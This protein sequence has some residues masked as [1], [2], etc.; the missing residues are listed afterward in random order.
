[1]T[2]EET[3]IPLGRHVK[4][5]TG[6]AYANLSSWP[7]PDEGALN[8]Q[9]LKDYQQRKEGIQLY[10][11][12]ASVAFIRRECGLE[13]KYIY[14]L[15][16]ERCL[17]VHPDGLIYGWRGIVPRLHIKP[18]RR[19]KLIS[20]D[21]AGFG[22]AGAL[23]V[24]LELHPDL[25]TKFDQRILHSPTA[26]Q[27]GPVQRPRQSLWKWFLDELRKLGYETRHEWPFNTRTN[28]Y[29][30][31]RKY[32]DSILE[33]NPGRA[34]RVIGG[35]DLGRKMLSGDGVD[36]PV[37]HVYQRVEMDAHKID[38]IFCVLLP[39]SAGGYVPKIIYRIWVI[40]IIEIVSR[41][42]L[43]YF[44][45]LRREVS[46]EDVLRT[47][48]IALSSWSPRKLSFS[49]I[50]YA[51]GAGFPSN[52]SPKLFRACWNETSVDGA[53]AETC[54]H[55]RDS[56]KNVVGSVLVSPK[57]GFSSR[58]SK[59]DRPFIEAFFKKLGASGF[60]RISN[61]TGGK[62]GGTNGRD[63]SKV[64]IKSQF[65]I[66][67]AEELL[68]VLIANYNATP[69]TALGYRSP[70]Q[71]LDFIC[72]RNDL[73]LRYADPNSVQALLSYR[74]RCRVKGGIRE[75]RRPYVNFEGAR[76]TN[77]ILGQRH[78]LVGSYIWLI[79][80][81]EDDARVAQ[82]STID[83]MSLGIL[84][85]AA[86]W[87]KLPHSLQVRRAINSCVHQRMLFIASGSDAVEAFLG[88]CEQQRNHKLPVHPAYLEARRI[89]VQEAE[90]VVGKP[91]LEVASEQQKTTLQKGHQ[92][93]I[94]TDKARQD[95]EPSTKLLPVRRKAVST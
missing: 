83:G 59:D 60:Q 9:K 55:V 16:R 53:L 82:A 54:Q 85:A 76:Y 50:A 44:L 84:R 4:G 3:I 5:L 42:I 13:P 34:V 1:M 2:S 41:A 28:G 92:E 26:D 24:T 72:S 6:T 81:L 25:K 64:A 75:G 79:N 17:E 57:S 78:D 65:Q 33:A 93:K 56:L 62:A 91:M 37:S 61:T 88:F 51:D 14:R 10:L 73:S 45:S 94:G 15:I 86:P 87:H 52:V 39:Q 27:L 63:P 46:K 47:I 58:R 7:L 19:K 48:K 23:T 20:V 36:R 31:V 68:D 29:N 18:Y 35:P 71:Y 80:H 69:H 21:A 74:K 67:Y 12:G 38:G 8:G 49:D 30:S 43:G 40:V 89:L 95:K 66:E 11:N 90:L 22:A 32:I 77:D 70:L